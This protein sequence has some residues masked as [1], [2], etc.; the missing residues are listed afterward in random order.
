M[1]GNLECS[2]TWIFKTQQGP[3][4]KMQ[5]LAFRLGIEPANPT[6]LVRCSAN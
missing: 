3:V 5:L 1:K 4:A 2:A 6:N